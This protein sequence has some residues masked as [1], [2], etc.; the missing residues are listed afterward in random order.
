MVDCTV[1]PMKIPATRHTRARMMAPLLFLV[2]LHV[3]TAGFGTEDGAVR[4]GRD[5]LRTACGGVGIFRHDWHK[6]AHRAVARAADAEPALVGGIAVR[7]RLRIGH[8]DGVVG[9]DE[10]AAR[11]AE[12]PPL[13]EELSVLVEDLDA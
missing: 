10:D 13:L 9:G 11:T 8:V 6:R 4:A 12:L 1:A 2:D 3:T 7:V 5:P